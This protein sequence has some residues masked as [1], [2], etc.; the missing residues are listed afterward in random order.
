MS[1]MSTTPVEPRPVKSTPEDLTPDNLTPANHF[2]LQRIELHYGL[3]P[4]I[5]VPLICESSIRVVCQATKCSEQH[6][7]YALLHNGNDLNAAIAE[8][9][10]WT[11]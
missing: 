1:T 6:A 8:I 2:E 4:L 7:V 11:P 10:V 3:D 5:R 9:N